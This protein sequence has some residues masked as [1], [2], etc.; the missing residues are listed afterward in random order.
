[1][2]T[3]TE[4]EMARL[5]EKVEVLNGERGD[6]SRRALRA[7][8]M[9][10]AMQAIIVPAPLASPVSGTPT[11]AEHNLLVTDL[12]ALRAVVVA[13]RKALAA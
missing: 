2:A 1:M 9:R 8:E 6:R 7:S 11:E 3:M 12:A 13:I 5:R 10:A 4:S